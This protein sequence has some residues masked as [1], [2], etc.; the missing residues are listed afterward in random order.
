MRADVGGRRKKR[1]RTRADGGDEGF[2][3]LQRRCL[4]LPLILI[5]SRSLRFA[6]SFSVADQKSPQNLLDASRVEELV[7]A[8]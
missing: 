3:V 1:S 6:S 8:G 2:R 4:A 5:D 7:E